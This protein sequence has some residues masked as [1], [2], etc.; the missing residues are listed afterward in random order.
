MKFPKQKGKYSSGIQPSEKRKF[1]LMI[2]A[3]FYV[4]T[5]I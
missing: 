1:L 4:T 5:C 3:L 2:I